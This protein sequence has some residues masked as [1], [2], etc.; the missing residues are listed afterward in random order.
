MQSAN[1]YKG[2]RHTG[3]NSRE[4]TNVREV[5]YK[6]APGRMLGPDRNK[7]KCMKRKLLILVALVAVVCWLPGQAAADSSFN[8]FIGI[9]NA[10]LN[11]YPSPYL[12]VTITLG[13]GADAG[14]ALF[15]VKSVTS[16]DLLYLFGG[17]MLWV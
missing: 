11:P 5:N 3:N 8:F 7:E 17:T 1:T 16:G 14:K 13:S 2:V 12:N 6:A 10:D 15:D 9:P 4:K